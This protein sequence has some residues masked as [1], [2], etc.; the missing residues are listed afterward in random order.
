MIDAVKN[1][2]A[3]AAT[4]HISLCLNCEHARRV[5]ANENAVY[6]LCELSLTNSA[7]PKYPRLPVL[8]CSGYVESPR[9][10]SVSVPTVPAATEKKCPCCGKIFTCHRQA[11]CWCA[12]VRLTPA[13]L[14]AL[15]ARFADCV[16]EA[17]LLKEAV[18]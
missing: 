13:A 14:D 17:C 11:G 12:D 2:L 7:F 8:G 18:K 5:E 1:K 9:E 16:C 15:R 6:F 4:S 3:V 10:E